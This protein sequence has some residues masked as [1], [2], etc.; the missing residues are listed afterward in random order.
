MKYLHRE[1]KI[2]EREIDVLPCPFCGSEDLTIRHINGQWGYS[3]SE[4]YVEC[5]YCKARGGYIEDSQCGNNF[6]KAIKN[7]NMREN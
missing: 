3:N 5:N 7:W 4:D 2:V 1:S 6:E